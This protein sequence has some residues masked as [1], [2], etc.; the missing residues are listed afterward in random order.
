MNVGNQTHNELPIKQ[1]P[2]EY[3]HLFEVEIVLESGYRYDIHNHSP[4]V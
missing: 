1:F 2:N 3:L 4:I